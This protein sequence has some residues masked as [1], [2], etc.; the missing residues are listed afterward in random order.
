M[1]CR[2]WEQKRATR[3]ALAGGELP[4]HL[5]AVG[6]GRELFDEG[7][8]VKGR[9]A[10]L[11]Q[12]SAIRR[13]QG[14]FDA[15]EEEAGGVVLMLVGVEDVCSEF[16]EQI[17]NPR[18]QTTLVGAIDQQNRRVFHVANRIAAGWEATGLQDYRRGKFVFV[19]NFE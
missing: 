4:A 8:Q 17:G 19:S 9:A 10:A 11:V 16:V 1:Q 15:H 6:Q 7:T 13:T 3:W 12:R 5:K 14:P 18:H 2:Y